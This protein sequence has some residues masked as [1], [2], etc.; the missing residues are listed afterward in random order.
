MQKGAVSG[1]WTVL[2]SLT[3]WH[4]RMFSFLKKEIHFTLIQEILKINIKLKPEAFLL[5]FMDKK[6]KARMFSEETSIIQL[7]ALFMEFCEGSI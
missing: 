2:Q 5:G 3:D 7:V 6:K 4:A 1:N